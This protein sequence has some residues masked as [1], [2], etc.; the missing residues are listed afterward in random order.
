[1]FVV[2]VLLKRLM[3]QKELRGTARPLV[4]VVLDEL[5]KYAP[6]YGWSPIRDVLLDISERGRSL[7]LSLFG[8]QQMASE[9][10]RRVVANSALKVVGRLDAGEAEQSEYGFLTETARRR[11]SLLQPG[12][13]IV[14]QPDLTTP[15][16]LRFPFPAWATRQSEAAPP[17]PEHDPFSRAG[18]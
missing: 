1:M 3:A 4:F 11:A 9:V 14:S 10:E 7:G 17:G 8:A 5:N 18:G 6:R 16:L 15:L 13:L 12:S 2:G